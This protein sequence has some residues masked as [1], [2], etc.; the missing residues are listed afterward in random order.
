MADVLPPEAANGHPDVNTGTA[1]TDTLSS[2][3]AAPMEQPEPVVH[4]QQPAAPVDTTVTMSPTETPLPPVEQQAASSDLAQAAHEAGIDVSRYGSEQELAQAMVGALQQS[5]PYVKF[6]RQMAPHAEQFQNYLRDGTQP[7]VQQQAPEQAPAPVQEEWDEGK[8]FADKCS[9]PTYDPNWDTFVQTGMIVQDPNSGQ[10]MPSPDYP[11]APANVIQ[12]LNEHRSWQRDSLQTLLENPYQKNWEA[13]QEP[14]QRM[15][16]ERIQQMFSGYDTANY[17]QDFE[18]RHAEHLYVRDENGQYQQDPVSGNWE[19]TPLGSLFYNE[20]ES[21]KQEG[22]TDPHAITERAL[23]SSVTALRAHA[24]EHQNAQMQE[25]YQGDPNAQQ[26]QMQ[27]QQPQVQQQA[28]DQRQSFM[29]RAMQRAAH[30]SSSSGYGDST[31]AG[32]HQ[33]LQRSELENMFSSEW[34]QQSGAS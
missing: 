1:F 10:F 25:Y 9:K 5:Q 12:G 16:D 33:G 7:P 13:M 6:A 29:D 28:P 8:H 20:I 3:P 17:I 4:H 18:G 21:L 11:M 19:L 2:Q 15:V 24:A 34:R 26:Q 14:M 30:T 32:E 31:P 23:D 22:M 27:P